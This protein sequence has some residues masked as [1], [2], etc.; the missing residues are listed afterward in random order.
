MIETVH[1]RPPEESAWAALTA[2]ADKFFGELG[3]LDPSWVAR[4]CRPMPRWS[5]S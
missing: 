4:R 2:A 5:A 1:G 3:E